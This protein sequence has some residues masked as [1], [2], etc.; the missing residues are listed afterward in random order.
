MFLFHL[1]FSLSCWTR[2]NQIQLQ[3]MEGFF[4]A[5]FQ[6]SNLSVVFLVCWLARSKEVNWSNLSNLTCVQKNVGGQLNELT[7]ILYA[8]VC[9]AL[10]H[11]ETGSS[12]SSSSWLS[13]IT[14]CVICSVCSKWQVKWCMWLG[15]RKTNRKDQKHRCTR[16]THKHR[17]T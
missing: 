9:S 5:N 17:L 13:V 16:V 7:I 2:A 10:P 12:L 6:L 15:K 11:S 1:L 4:L 14:N 3:V 8:H